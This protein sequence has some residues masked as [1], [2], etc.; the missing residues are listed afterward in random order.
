MLLTF[1]LADNAAAS[2][3]TRHPLVFVAGNALTPSANTP[4]QWG[5]IPARLEACGARISHVNWDNPLGTIEAKGIR[6]ADEISIILA[7]TGAY[8][9]NLIA[10]S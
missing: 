1:A 8:K 6:L 9:V 10:R 2:C 3:D 5:R 4:H 7:Q